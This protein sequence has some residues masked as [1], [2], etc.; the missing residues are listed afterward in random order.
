MFLWSY[1]FCWSL[2]FMLKSFLRCL[3]VLGYAFVFVIGKAGGKVWVWAA[4]QC[5]VQF[6]CWVS[7]IVGPPQVTTSVGL[8]SRVSFHRSFLRLPVWWQKLNL[9]Q[10]SGSWGREK[11]LG[12]CGSFCSFTLYLVF[13]VVFPL[14]FPVPS[15]PPTPLLPCPGCPHEPKSSH[16]KE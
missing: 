11:E 12:P 15:I 5:W 1:F 7:F 3:E 13:C 2:S 14:P 9:C 4:V 8:F 16:S 10:Y 6:H